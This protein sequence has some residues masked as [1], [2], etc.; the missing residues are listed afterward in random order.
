[1]SRTSR[2]QFDSN[3]QLVNGFDYDLQCWVRGGRV[4]DCGHP[5]GSDCD[6]TG[7]R[8]RGRKIMLVRRLEGLEQV[9]GV[10]HG[11]KKQG[12]L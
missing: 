5:A 11:M 7:R 9:S 4:V 6:C 1:M 10:Y 8:H 12:A 3:G 2:D